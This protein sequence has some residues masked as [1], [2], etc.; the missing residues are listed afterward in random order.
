MPRLVRL[1]ALPLLFLIAAAAAPAVARAQSVATMERKL[2]PYRLGPLQQMPRT[3]WDGLSFLRDEEQR[4]QALKAEISFGLSGDEAGDR[5]LFKLNTGIG[6]SRGVFPSEVSV[7]A[8]LFLQVRDGQ[9]QEDVTSLQLTYDYHASHTVQYFA[10]AERFTDS[11][12]S[13]QQR[14]EIGFGA[15]MGWQFGQVGNWRDTESAFDAVRSGLD[16]LAPQLATLR[17]ADRADAA[18]A[19]APPPVTTADL[20]AFRSAMA[21]LHHSLEDRQ[22]RLL[23][24]IAA[25]IFAEI[26]NPSHDVTSVPVAAMPGDLSDASTRRISLGSEQRFRLSVRPTIKFR[27]IPEVQIVVFPYFKLPLDGP[28]RVTG[29]DGARRLDYRRDVLSEMTWSIRR[30]QTGLESVEFVATL[31]HFFDNVPPQVPAALID[32]TLAAGRRVVNA[33]AER[34]HRVVAM[35]LRMRW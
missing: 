16:Q 19:G 8:R 27:P 18:T 6:L 25:S 33:Q 1:A 30:E 23:V 9:L 7:V 14:Y 28:R 5:S 4:Q 31:N 11:F 29:A 2:L 26:E 13:I 15:R 24:G 20:A 21:N 35:S 22:V 12:M 3:F 10:F 17:A 32:E 34:S